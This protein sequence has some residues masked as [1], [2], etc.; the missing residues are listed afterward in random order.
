MGE[1]E[2]AWVN[3]R[4]C[5]KCDTIMF[6]WYNADWEYYCN[7]E[8]LHTKYSETEWEELCEEEDSN[9]YYT[10]WYDEIEEI[11]NIIWLTL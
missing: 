11:E 1:L 8:C 4:M 2:K 7:R 10:E 3:V 5:E 6:D 9:C